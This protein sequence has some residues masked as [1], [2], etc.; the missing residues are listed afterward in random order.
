[1]SALETPPLAPLQ[2]VS[3]RLASAGVPHALGASGLCAALGLV[4]RV[5]DWDVT[6]DAELETL[7]TLFADRPSERFGNSGCHADHKLNLEGGAIELIAG[8]AFFVPGGIV[9]IPTI[10]TGIWNGVPVGSPEAWA[11]AYALMGELEDSP[12]RRERAEL[13]FGWLERNGADAAAVRT[14]LAEPL[15]ESIARRLRALPVR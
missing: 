9:R 15:P 5:N 1:M 12:R 4:E 13:V 2:A 8:F 14:L 10:V 11:V 7:A 3:R 6:C